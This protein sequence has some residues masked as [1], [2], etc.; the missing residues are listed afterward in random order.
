MNSSD[1]NKFQ[2]KIVSIKNGKGYKRNETV[3]AD[4]KVLN[5]KRTNLNAAEIQS[6]VRGAFVPKLWANCSLGS[7]TKKNETR[8]TR[9]MRR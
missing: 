3:T 1:G 6:I 5:S 4:G 2:R 7:R 9:K 8:K